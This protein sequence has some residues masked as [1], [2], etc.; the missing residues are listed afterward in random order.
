V[1]G[2]LWLQSSLVCHANAFLD[3]RIETPPEDLA[4]LEFVKKL[5]FSIDHSE[6]PIADSSIKWFEYLLSEG[7]DRATLFIDRYENGNT[8]I[9]LLAFA[10][11]MRSA[12]LTESG[13]REVIWYSSE[14]VLDIKDPERKIWQVRF[15][16][17]RLKDLL[18]RVVATVSESRTALTR[19]LT[20]LVTFC[21]DHQ[22]SEWGSSFARS[23][24]LV[25]E[26]IA[27]F[28]R[29]ANVFPEV[30]YSDDVKALF[31]AAADSWCFG[32]MGSWNDMG[33]TDKVVQARYESVSADHYKAIVQ[34]LYATTAAYDRR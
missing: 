30:G 13:D 21:N 19:S 6:Q 2:S 11:A 28:D 14:E 32:G 29:P 27:S 33:F 23:L 16:G 25:D 26:P 34:V 5:S 7:F 4:G 9:N 20:D 22:L 18:P 24:A 17:S 3:G 31:F 8:D 1:I 10:G 15:D 12:V